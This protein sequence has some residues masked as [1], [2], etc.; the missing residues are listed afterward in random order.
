MYLS[1]LPTTHMDGSKVYEGLETSKVIP[2]LSSRQTS[3]HFG[4]KPPPTKNASF[5]RP[6]CRYCRGHSS[7]EE[8]QKPQLTVT[9]RSSRPWRH[10]TL[11]LPLI[12]TSEKQDLEDESD[13]EA[14]FEDEKD[15]DEE[16][17][18]GNNMFSTSKLD[19][20]LDGTKV[21]SRFK[22]W[23]SFGYNTY[24]LPQAVQAGKYDELRKLYRKFLYHN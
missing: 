10:Q 12:P 21:M 19:Q 24:N 8:S 2:Q 5:L 7:R 3:L 23:K 17:R 20:M 16:E 4:P 15:A 9:P 13:D 14:L 1:T 18:G 11:L 22:K 6:P